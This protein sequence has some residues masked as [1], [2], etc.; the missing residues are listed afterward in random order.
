MSGSPWMPGEPRPDAALLPRDA[1]DDVE[2]FLFGMDV[3]LLVDV[4]QMGAHGPLRDQPAPLECGRPSGP[5][6]RGSSPRSPWATAR[7]RR[8]LPGSGPGSAGA[9]LL[10][11][12]TILVLVARRQHSLKKPCRLA[13]RF[14]KNSRSNGSSGSSVSAMRSLSRN[15]NKNDSSTAMVATRAMKLRN[16]GEK[17]ANRSTASPATAPSSTPS[18][19]MPQPMPNTRV[20]DNR[21]VSRYF[22]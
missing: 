13:S 5:W 14:P 3:H 10:A 6:R 17:G 2:H 9:A 16:C 20:E 19:T 1:F 22:C 12:L 18:V 15:T 7:R 21:V 8:P 4:A 11:A